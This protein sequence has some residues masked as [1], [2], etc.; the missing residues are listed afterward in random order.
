MPDGR[1]C[2]FNVF[3]L[4]ILSY[5]YLMFR[6][7]DFSVKCINVNIRLLVQDIAE[8][9]ECH[10]CKHITIYLTNQILLPPDSGHLHHRKRALY[11]LQ[12]LLIS[13]NIACHHR[14]PHAVTITGVYP[15]SFRPHKNR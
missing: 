4:H 9:T 3:Q 14:L 7:D 11:S 13:I 15:G 2:R 12:L 1:I 6:R 10:N 5:F 8:L